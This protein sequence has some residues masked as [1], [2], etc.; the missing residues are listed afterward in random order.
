MARSKTKSDL[1]AKVP[2]FGACSRK[3]L[4]RIG[5]LADEVSVESGRLL[6]QAGRVGRE[7]FVIADGTAT[8]EIRGEVV[9]KL[10][11][12]DFFGEMAL[13]DHA[14]RSATVR[15]DTDMTL[16]VVDSR[17]FA[18]LLE[19]APTVARKILRGV[20]QRLR[21]AERAPTH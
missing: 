9:A 7:F 19:D 12:G 4:D 17:S 16:Y 20:A 21:K 10:G 3:E 14:P 18:S 13:L 1:L 11:S 8:V 6:T 2:L 5:A 15:A